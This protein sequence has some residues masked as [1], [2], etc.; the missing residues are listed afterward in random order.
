MLGAGGLLMAWTSRTRHCGVR[1]GDAVRGSVARWL[2]PSWREAGCSG[3]AGCG[4]LPSVAALRRWCSVWLTKRRRGRAGGSRGDPGLRRAA[5]SAGTRGR[6]VLADSSLPGAAGLVAAVR[7]ARSGVAHRWS[8]GSFPRE[9]RS[10]RVQ[11]ASLVGPPLCSVDVRRRR[12]MREGSG[13]QHVF[14]PDAASVPWGRR[15]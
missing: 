2:V 12:L 7:G 15:S 8:G 9:G 14:A 1:C 4:R 11:A 5:E 13:S 3:V 6:G 10:R